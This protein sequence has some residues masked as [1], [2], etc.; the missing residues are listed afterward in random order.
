MWT[1]LR[2]VCA[3][4]TFIFLQFLLIFLAH[5]LQ[6]YFLNMFKT[7]KKLNN[8]KTKKFRAHGRT[9]TLKYQCTADSNSLWCNFLYAGKTQNRLFWPQNCPSLRLGQYGN[10]KILGPLEKPREIVDYVFCPHKKI[11]FHFC[12]YYCGT[13]VL[14]NYSMQFTRFS[15][16]F[17]VVKVFTVF[18]SVRSFDKSF[19]DFHGGKT[20]LKSNLFPDIV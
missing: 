18:T 3:A 6:W 2:R 16:D 7:I 17:F 15:R 8:D 5:F 13:E 9:G 1:G 20:Y 4:L 11:S 19:E 12:S 14:Q 10:Q